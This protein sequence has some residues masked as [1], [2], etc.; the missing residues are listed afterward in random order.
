MPNMPDSMSFPESFRVNPFSL[1][2]AIGNTKN[3]AATTRRDPT[4]SAEN[5]TNPFLIRIKE[6][7]QIRA[8]IT[9][10]KI[11]VKS[12]FSDMICEWLAKVENPNAI[13][14]TESC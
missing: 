5:T 10:S 6:V 13:S 1:V 12:L 8:R 7:P 2:S 14:N 9:N 4:S 3:A 11:D